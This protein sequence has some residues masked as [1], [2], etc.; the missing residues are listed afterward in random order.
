MKVTLDLDRKIGNCRRLITRIYEVDKSESFPAGLKFACQYL[1]F[2]D[3]WIE[4]IRVDNY[5]HGLKRFGAHV[6]KL[7]AE[8][9]Q[10]IEMSIDQLET[11]VLAMGESLIKRLMLGEI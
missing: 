5:E 2:R 8:N 1:F 3:K 7:G 6:H 10:F 4:V 11:Y 9:T